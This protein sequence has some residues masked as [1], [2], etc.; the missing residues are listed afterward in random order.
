MSYPGVTKEESDLLAR[1]HAGDESAFREL[2]KCH[3]ANMIGFARSFTR[4][5]ET[6]ED[7]V[8]ETWV[9]IIEGL[10]RFEGRSSFKSY[11]YAILANKAKTRAVRDSRIKTF[12]ELAAPGYASGPELAVDPARFSASGSWREPPREW[13]EMTPE[14]QVSD[15]ELQSLL[16]QGIDQ[17]PKAQRAVLI[18]RDIEG[19]SAEEASNILGVTEVNHR[20]MLHRGRAKLRTWIEDKLT[21]AKPKK[22]TP[23]A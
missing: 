5:R 13:D 1:L 12:S 18:L 19:L 15:R 2:L 8:Q 10:A 16:R 6:A 20:V 14:R 11:I 17:L 3:H 23:H 21:A 9:A 4:S 22:G 7:V